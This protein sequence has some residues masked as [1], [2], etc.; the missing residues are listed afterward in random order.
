MTLVILYIGTYFIQQC[1]HTCILNIIVIYFQLSGTHFE[2]NMNCGF[3][4]PTVRKDL[5]QVKDIEG[6]FDTL[7]Y[8]RKFKSQGAF[9]VES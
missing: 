8:L 2:N 6:I 9:C 4:P 3:N 1:H 5:P 7:T